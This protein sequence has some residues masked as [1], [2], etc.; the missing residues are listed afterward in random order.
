MTDL[1]DIANLGGD[2]Y[3][4]FAHKV[5]KLNKRIEENEYHSL[6][7]NGAYKNEFKKINNEIDFQKQV[8]VKV[9]NELMR[10]SIIEILSKNI[11]DQKAEIDKIK[12]TNTMMI[13]RI[14][15]IERFVTYDYHAMANKNLML[16]KE[17]NKVYPAIAI[18]IA[19]RYP[20]LY[21]YN[22][23]RMQLQKKELHTEFKIVYRYIAK[24]KALLLKLMIF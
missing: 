23:E 19:R 16:H 2:C 22:Y 8:N 17:Y 5:E 18:R 15:H 3:Y 9:N 4:H 13:R 11:T 10:I 7:I 21:H 20:A 12:H 14:E 6:D 1:K 24:Q